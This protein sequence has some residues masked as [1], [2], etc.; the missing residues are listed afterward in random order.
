MKIIRI[1]RLLV[2][3]LTTM[4]NGCPGG[5]FSGKK[6]NNSSNNTTTNKRSITPPPKS[7]SK[8]GLFSGY[9]PKRSE[10]SSAPSFTD[11]SYSG[12]KS[13]YESGY[14]SEG[15]QADCD[16]KIPTAM[17]Q[18]A[19]CQSKRR[20]VNQTTKGNPEY[21]YSSLFE[22]EET[23]GNYDTRY[24]EDIYVSSIEEDLGAIQP[25]DYDNGPSEQEI[26]NKFLEKNPALPKNLGIKVSIYH[27]LMKVIILTDRPINDKYVR[28]LYYTI[29]QIDLENA[30]RNKD[31]GLIN[32]ER[33]LLA[34]E[35]LKKVKEKNPHLDT[36]MLQ[37]ELSAYHDADYA[38]IS[39]NSLSVWGRPYT[40]FA[41]VTYTLAK[42]NDS[43]NEPIFNLD[44]DKVEK[45]L[46]RRDY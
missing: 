18:K 29:L 14:E 39:T 20:N 21:N 35:I 37:V 8:D 23:Q 2:L 41:R 32:C 19:G 30:V 11:N 33:D 27:L 28:T 43:S 40:N 16:T 6:S 31:L 46:K 42:Q 38:F 44:P 10:F 7:G 5:W 24:K 13:G 34:Q 36:S 3:G 9:D 1:A 22:E 45:A 26:I 4:N 12:Y 17:K 25:A 15:S